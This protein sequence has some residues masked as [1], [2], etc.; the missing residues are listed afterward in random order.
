MGMLGN[1]V[2]GLVPMQKHLLYQSCVV[3]VMTYGLGL[4]F[5][6]GACI[7]GSIKALAQIQSAAACWITGGFRTTPIGGMLALAGLLPM[8]ILLK[9]LADKG[10]LRASLLVPSHPLRTILGVSLR[11]TALAHPLGLTSLGSLSPG[12]LLGPVS[13]SMSAC[14]DVAKD[15]IDPFGA[16]S[17][18]GSQVL[19]LWG[20]RTSQHAPLSKDKEDIW[21]YIHELDEVWA[22][23]CADPSCLV[24]A[25]DGSVPWAT[26]QGCDRLVVFSDSRPALDSLLQVHPHS[27]QMFSLDACKS[28]RPWF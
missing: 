20:S 1:S 17:Y 3:P 14:V 7:Q 12:S 22:M 10:A 16:E 13:D 26:A 18:P 2:R 23:A 9:R 11:G 8:H 21:A 15:E 4:W 27:G 28:L 5:F 19:D 6:K 25:A 24:V